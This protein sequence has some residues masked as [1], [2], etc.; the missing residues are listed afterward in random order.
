MK[1]K[2]H[3]KSGPSCAGCDERL[4]QGHET[5][6]K[7]FHELK[8][9]F[10][11]LHCFTVYRNEEDQNNAFIAKASRLKYPNSKHNKIPAEAIDLFQINEQRKAVFDPMF[12]AKVNAKAKELGFELEWGGEW[13]T[14]KDFP[15]FQLKS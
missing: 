1:F 9:L 7:F 13:K 15:H 12:Y 2:M 11:D 14:L 10:H 6:Q 4:L 3:E 8:I 5:I